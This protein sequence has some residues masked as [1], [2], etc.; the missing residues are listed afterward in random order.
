MLLS[1]ETCF[2]L[3]R[4]ALNKR[5]R[6]TSKSRT[7]KSYFSL[8]LFN[9]LSQEQEEDQLMAEDQ[10]LE[11]ECFLWRKNTVTSNFIPSSPV[12]FSSIS[13]SIQ[14]TFFYLCESLL[15]LFSFNHSKFHCM[16]LQ[17]SGKITSLSLSMKPSSSF[18]HANQL[19]SNSLTNIL[20]TRKQA[21]TLAIAE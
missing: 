15:F 5:E 17:V 9:W 18:I 3:S 21:K 13:S 19:A 7:K 12:S 8:K 1:L 2:S 11:K 4:C 14:Q 10:W 20:A 6:E 16:H